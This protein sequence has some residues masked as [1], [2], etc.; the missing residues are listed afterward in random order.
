MEPNHPRDP[1]EQY[2]IRGSKPGRDKKS[3]YILDSSAWFE[4]P[5]SFPKRK[6]I[7]TIMNGM[8]NE[9]AAVMIEDTH[10]GFLVIIDLI[11]DKFIYLN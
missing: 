10:A 5:K 6:P 8:N 2:I 4:N 9:A 11:S 1:A 3:P 7:P